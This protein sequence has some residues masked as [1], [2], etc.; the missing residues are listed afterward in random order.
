MNGLVNGLFHQGGVM[1][2]FLCWIGS[3][4]FGCGRAVSPI[5]SIP[6]IRHFIPS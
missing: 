1:F 3:G 5:K 6:S 4:V 2:G